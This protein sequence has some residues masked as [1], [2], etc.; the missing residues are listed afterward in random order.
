MKAAI[1]NT[2]LITLQGDGLGII[3]DGVVSFSEGKIDFVGKEREFNKDNV[4][5]IIDGENHVTMPGLVNAHTHTGPTLLRGGAQDVPE[6][7]WMNKAIGPLANHL[8]S[9]DLVLG[10][11]LG[12][13]EGLRSGI[14]TFGEYTSDVGMLIKNVYQPFGVR[15]AA[16]EI[17]NEVI[18]KK[19][20]LEPK[21]LYKLDGEKGKKALD[22]T[23]KLFSRYRD[24]ELVEVMYGP[25][26]LDMVSE[27]TLNEVKGRAKGKKAKIHMHVAQGE[28]ERLQIQGRY[29]KETSTVKVLKHLDMLDEQL[30]AV[31]CHDT[32]DEEKELM[33]END[34]DMIG[35]P[36]SIAMIDGIVPPV[37]EFLRSGGTVGLGTDQAPG[38]GTHNM[39][40]EMRTISILTKTKYSDPTQL[41]PWKTIKLGCLGG[42]EVLD[43]DDKIGSLEVGKAADIIT[44]DLSK[45]NLIPSVSDPFHN[46]IPNLVYS[47]TGFEVDNVIINGRFVLEDNEFLYIDDKKVIE[48]AQERGEYIFKDAAENWG[49]SGCYL[50]DIA[51][52]G[53]I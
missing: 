48:E 22:K 7:E 21:E 20:K 35:C 6:I 14:T 51:R 18:S 46:F 11:K 4:D 42:A 39:F 19:E 26:A 45:V 52:K 32:T 49:K 9:E 28:R 33:T 43:M 24:G 15:V 16:T 12:V 29:G 38:Q 30:L 50:V 13:I 27:E 23:E 31:H 37:S 47:S 3:D 2:R 8:K 1:V 25:Q 44:I 40:R 10:S 36:S 17:I 5:R 34:V 53:L 41:P